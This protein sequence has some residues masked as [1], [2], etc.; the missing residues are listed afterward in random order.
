MNEE[1]LGRAGDKWST[2]VP[3]QFVCFNA[4]GK[5]DVLAKNWDERMG[6]LKATPL[7]QMTFCNFKYLSEKLAGALC[8]G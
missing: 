7:C 3:I 6:L 2:Q 5:F 8:Y 4:K 1:T